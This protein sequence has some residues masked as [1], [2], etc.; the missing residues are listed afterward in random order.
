[1]EIYIDESGNFAT[2]TDGSTFGVVG[3]LVVTESQFPILQQR[4]AQLR[5]LLPKDGSE[6]KGRELAESDVARVVD[7]AY[8][9]G[10]IYEA[11]PVYLEPAD[12]S[13]IE[14]HRAR[15][16]EGL[17]RELTDQYHP[18]VVAAFHEL[19]QRLERMPLQLYVQSI[20]TFDVLWKTMSHATAYH[21][22]REPEALGRFRWQFD[23][24]ARDGITDWEDWLSKLVKPMM[25]SR[26]IDHPF[27]ELQDGD[28]SHM[29][30]KEIPVPEYLAKQFPRLNGKT[31]RDL[32]PAFNEMQFSAEMLPGLELVDVLTNA[33][34]RALMKRLDP[35]GWIGI[36][37][38]MI[39]RTGTSY[40]RPFGFGVEERIAPVEVAAVLRQFRTCGRSM[41]TEKLS[42]D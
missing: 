40:I 18:G 19:R 26:S 24:K 15:Q 9:S 25:Q 14:T 35:A 20:A 36:R 7:V 17:T 33:I 31:G 13:A 5:P 23:A 28:Y 38:L 8:R 29:A 12:F 37:K 10:L 41:L 21:S 32:S 16:C 39:H 6:V 11:T 22:Q 42:R 2:R 1:M 30:A 4:Y 3:A 27:V 34:R